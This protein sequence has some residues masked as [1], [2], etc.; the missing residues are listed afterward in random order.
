MGFRCL[1][2]LWNSTGI[3]FV[4]FRFQIVPELWVIRKIQ[5]CG[6]KLQQSFARNQISDLWIKLVPQR[7][8]NHRDHQKLPLLYEAGWIN[9]PLLW[10]QH[11]GGLLSLYVLWCGS[12]RCQQPIFDCDEAYQSPQIQRQKRAWEPSLRHCIQATSW[13]LERYFWTFIGSSILERSVNY[14]KDDFVDW[15]LKPL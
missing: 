4:A 6:L 9:E 10:P 3:Y 15:H 2:L 13:P 14:H 7:V 11:H 5:Y 1:R 12:P 8:Q